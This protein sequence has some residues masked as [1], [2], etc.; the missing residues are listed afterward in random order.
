MQD[1]AKHAW[2]DYQFS[3]AGAVA[4]QNL[5]N[6]SNGE[7]YIAHLMYQTIVLSVQ[8]SLQVGQISGER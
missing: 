3:Q 1:C 6:N 2:E 8:G 5:Y 4:Y 7:N